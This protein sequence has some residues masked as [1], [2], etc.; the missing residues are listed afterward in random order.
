MNSLTLPGLTCLLLGAAVAGAPTPPPP[1]FA[2]PVVSPVVTADRKVT[3]RLRTT[4]DEA[5]LTSPDIPGLG[6][7]AMIKNADGVHELTVGPLPPGAYRYLY[8]VAGVRTLDPVNPASSEGNANAFS[9]LLVPG[10]ELF[11]TRD[12]PHGAVATVTYAAQTRGSQRRM[13]VYTPPDYELGKGSYPVLYLLHGATDSDDSWV[14]IGRMAAILDNLIAAGRA[15][16]M[17]VVMP[18]GHTGRFSRAPGRNDREVELCAAEVAG[19]IRPFMESHY[20]LLPGRQNRAVAGLSMGGAQA[21]EI[22]ANQFGDFGYLGVFSSGIFSLD[23]DRPAPTGP[24]WEERHKAALDDTELRKGLRV[25]WFAIGRE[26]FL[27]K[28]S[29]ATVEMLG[30][31]G[32]EVKVKETDGGHGWAN[33][34]DYLGEWLPMLFKTP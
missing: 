17:V 19:D 20:R 3:F 6:P 7:G 2:P 21:L 30:R 26:D 33:W 34:R 23:P 8:E 15:R 1:P 32:F 27:L 12:V 5:R 10:S 18:N 24:S 11:D 28:V 13:H 31:H 29:R 16:P 9:L 14:T 25:V 4:A 22:A